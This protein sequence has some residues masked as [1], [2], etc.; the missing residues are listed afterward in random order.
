MRST[1]A[2]VGLA[3]RRR[4]ACAC[5]ADRADRQTAQPQPS[6]GTPKLVPVPRKVSFTPGASGTARRHTV[7]TF[8]RF[9][10]P[11]TSNGTPAVTTTRSPCSRQPLRAH[12][13]ERQL[14]HV[15]V[16]VAVRHETGDDAPHERELAVGALLIGEH[17][18]RHAG[19]VR[20]DD[21]RREAA[22]GED[23]ER[24]ARRGC[25]PRDVAAAAIAMLRGDAASGVARA[26]RRARDG[27]CFSISRMMR[28]IASTA[29]RGYCP[30]AVSAESITASVPSRIAFATSLASARVGRG[31]RDHRLEHLRRGDHR[32][33][34]LVA[35]R[36]DALLRDRHLLERQLDAEVA[37]RD[38]HRVGRAHD[39]LDVLERG[40]LLDL[41]DDEH[42]LRNLR[43][44]LGDVGGAS[45][46]AEREVLELCSTAKAT[47]AQSFS[48]ID[49]ALTATPGRFIPLWLLMRAAVEHARRHASCAVTSSATSSIRP[50][51]TRMRSPTFTSSQR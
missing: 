2:A 10:V 33:A 5:R 24:T 36:D 46:E 35:E 44:Q 9:V 1:R 4:R 49:G 7:S 23:D 8:I 34:E 15:A 17:E 30:A 42:L 32:T 39:A 19:P 18:D 48:V 40:V 43:A 22:L 50:S 14:H 27:G 45:H 26:R 28:D 47:S 25:A 13:V 41:R 3:R 20:R 21:A 16:G 38:H 51:S 31:L 6:C 11:G 37:A 12:G 29:S